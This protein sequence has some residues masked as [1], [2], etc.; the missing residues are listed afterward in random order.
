M[1]QLYLLRV[2]QMS[3]ATPYVLRNAM[4]AFQ[5]NHLRVLTEEEIVSLIP[6]VNERVKAFRQSAAEK[7]SSKDQRERYLR[8]KAE[9]EYSPTN[10]EITYVDDKNVY[11]IAKMERVR[12]IGLKAT[13][14]D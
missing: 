3:E 5:N 10:H 14:N 4:M 11:C 1:Q 12:G 8:V 7:F 13:S 6:S 9:A 2:T